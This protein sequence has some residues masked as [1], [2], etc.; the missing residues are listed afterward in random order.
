MLKQNTFE[1]LSSG[2]DI[3]PANSA[4]GGDAFDSVAGNAQISST[5]PARGLVGGRFWLNNSNASYVRWDNPGTD[6]YIRFYYR[7]TDAQHNARLFWYGTPA[8]TTNGW[9]IRQQPDEII[10]VCTRNTWRDG[11]ASG[12]NGPL[13]RIEAHVVTGASGHIE[14][15]IY[16]DSDGS[17][18][19]TLN[20]G[21]RQIDAASYICFG[22][23]NGVAITPANQAYIDEIAYSD[24]G[25][26]GEPV[27]LTYQITATYPTD[28]TD[29]TSWEVDATGSSGVLTLTQ[30]GGTTASI[31]E[32]P[33]G[34]FTITNPTGDDA[35]SFNLVSDGVTTL[36]LVFTRG[37]GL[38]KPAV[39][40][41]QAITDNSID[42]WA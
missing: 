25:W 32:S 31:V 29:I 23:S 6:F 30:T 33:T 11:M 10:S 8:S 5:D 4:N 13:L 12:L 34:V 3:T 15:R 21:V 1:G 36:P 14:V 9:D 2:T 7:T 22:L 35:L 40:T 26:I 19:D 27:G 38:P 18:L 39:W 24:T 41:R 17:L 16:D 42:D 28:S 20:T 37:A